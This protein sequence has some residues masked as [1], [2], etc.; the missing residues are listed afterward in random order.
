[1]FV[2]G[3]YVRE[4][5]LGQHRVGR[6]GRAVVSEDDVLLL[7]AALYDL[8][9]SS[10]QFILDLVDDRN[11]EGSNDG[12][13]ENRQLLL[14]LLNDL[15]QDGDFVNGLGNTLHDIVVQLDGW[16]DLL[17]DLLDV[18]SVLLRLPGGNAHV[19]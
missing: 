5:I 4:M 1:M 18:E 8:S 13:D 6:V 9:R 10:P 17:E 15:G 3:T 19:L 16:H 12:K 11:D 14:K 7:L 2:S